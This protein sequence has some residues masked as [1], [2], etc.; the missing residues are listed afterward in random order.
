MAFNSPCWDSHF[1]GH[2][3]FLAPRFQFPLLGFLLFCAKKNEIKHT[4]QFPLLGFELEDEGQEGE[5]SHFQFPLLG[6]SGTRA[7]GEAEEGAFNSPCW[8]SIIHRTGGICL[9][10]FNSPCWD[11]RHELPSV[12][13][14]LLPFNS[15]CW[16]STITEF[17]KNVKAATFNSP[18]WDSLKALKALLRSWSLSIPLVGIL[19]AR[20]VRVVYENGSTFNSPCWDSSAVNATGNYALDTF[21]SPCWDSGLNARSSGVSGAL[22]IPLVGIPARASVHMAPRRVCF[23]FPLLGFTSQ[24]RT[25]M[26]NT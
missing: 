12:K 10:S 17:R 20:Y 16:D 2:N 24:T 23:Q 15:P 4:F 19:K 6:F 14:C 22:S 7:E 25:S 26:A 21:N 9:N 1:Q 8:D 18:C 5:A 11:S 13:L 3:G